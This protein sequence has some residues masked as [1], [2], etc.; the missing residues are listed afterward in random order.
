MSAPSSKQQITVSEL[1]RNAKALLESNFSNIWVEGEI[2]NLA[3]PSS[4]H[5]YF[6]LKDSRSQVRCAM[7]RGNNRFINFTPEAGQQVMVRAKLSLYEA[8]GDYQLIVDKME[9][10]GDGALAKAFEQLKAK[11]KSEG[12]FDQAHKQ[13]LPAMVSNVAVITS[14][15]GAAIQDILTVFERR[16]PSISITIVPVAVQ[17]EQAAAQIRDAIIEV[18]NLVAKGKIQ[19]DVILTGRGGGSL[20]D[21]WAFNDEQLARAIFDSSLPVVSAVGHE[22]DFTIADFVADVRAPT[23]SAAAELL[24]PDQEEWLQTFYGYEQLLFKTVELKILRGRER[25][26]Q[27]QSRLK[28]PGNVIQGHFQRLDELEGRLHRA[29]QNNLLDQRRQVELLT[30]RVLQNTPEHEIENYSLRISALNKKLKSEMKRTIELK[31]NQI[32]S[33]AQLLNSVN[34]LQI[35]DRG[36]S[37]AITKEGKIVKEAKSVKAG[38][39]LITQLGKGKLIST[40]EKVINEKSS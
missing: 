11:L 6:T 23:P 7:F 3:Q 14:P 30:S 31:R 13:E 28:H 22:V 19:A 38:D 40:V 37:I 17:G 9:P 26:A 25:I 12:L 5:W 39:Q 15:T 10:A 29:C 16:F 34:P 24:S 32:R 2:S 35:L 4:G 21:L 18:N 33:N 8:R 20:E 36:Y 27:L 1:N